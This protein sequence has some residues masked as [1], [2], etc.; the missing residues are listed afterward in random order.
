MAEKITAKNKNVSQIGLSTHNQD[1]EINPV[2]FNTTKI[3]V[4]VT[5]GSIPDRLA[6]FSIRINTSKFRFV[7]L[8]SSQRTD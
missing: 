3:S 1:H 5:M 6:F 8:F 4:K 7:E 2:A